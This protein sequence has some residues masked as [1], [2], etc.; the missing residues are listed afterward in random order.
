MA[1]PSLAI[2]AFSS[3][4]WMRSG[5]GHYS[6]TIVPFLVIA[7]IYG[8]DWVAGKVGQVGAVVDW[9]DWDRVLCAVVCW[10]GWGWRWRWCTTTTT[11]SRRCR[12]ALRWSR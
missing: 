5:G 9:D 8:V 1:L 6:A 7:A 2:N 12:G 3:Y 4:D 10:W 11:A